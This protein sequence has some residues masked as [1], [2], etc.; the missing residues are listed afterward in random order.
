[1]ATYSGGI[2]NAGDVARVAEQLRVIWN[3]RG[4]ADLV[5]I[6]D[7]LSRVMGRT[8]AGANI[9]DPYLQALDQALRKLDR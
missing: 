1:M 8:S 4:A 2:I 9:A 7:V 5:T 3:A 6:T